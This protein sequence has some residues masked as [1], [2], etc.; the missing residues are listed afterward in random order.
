F[1]FETGTNVKNMSRGVT[2]VGMS[3]AQGVAGLARGAA[4]GV[5]NVA[6]GTADLTQGAADAVKTTLGLSNS[7]NTRGTT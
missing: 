7:N 1:F 6:Q 2:H 4:V 3:A 5:G